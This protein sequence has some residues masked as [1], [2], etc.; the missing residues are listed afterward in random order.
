MCRNEY[1]APIIKEKIKWKLWRLKIIALYFQTYCGTAAAIMSNTYLEG[2]KNMNLNI[3]L[4]EAA[5]DDDR[6]EKYKETPTA[7]GLADCRRSDARPH[8]LRLHRAWLYD[9]WRMKK[10]AQIFL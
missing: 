4:K 8:G 2:D 9:W 10:W 7:E 3:E 1:S 6:K 5:Q